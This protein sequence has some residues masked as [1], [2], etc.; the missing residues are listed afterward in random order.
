LGE[1]VTIETEV[2]LLAVRE[3]RGRSVVRL[4]I[5]QPVFRTDVGFWSCAFRVFENDLL[6]ASDAAIGSDALQAIISGISG[7]RW[8]FEDGG[9]SLHELLEPGQFWFDD[10]P[11]PGLPAF[12]PQ[13]LG[14]EFDQHLR[15]V[16]A[17][18]VKARLRELELK[19]V[20]T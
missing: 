10:E 5:D 6:L 17:D 2:R 16:I 8:Q 13:G 18:A 20:G 19:N 4:E 7:L 1:P 11:G 3:L 14:K 9:G 12:L 15:N